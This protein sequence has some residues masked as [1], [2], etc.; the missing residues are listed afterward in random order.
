LTTFHGVHVCRGKEFLGV[1]ERCSFFN[2]GDFL[3]RIYLL[4][5]NVVDNQMVDETP[6]EYTIYFPD[7]TK[8]T[9][10]LSMD[11]SLL[12]TDGV[13]YVTFSFCTEEVVFET[14]SDVELL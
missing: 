3:Q 10:V 13:T 12:E 11:D 4:D 1:F 8:L 9:A 7:E 5:G 14:Q 6:A 2:D